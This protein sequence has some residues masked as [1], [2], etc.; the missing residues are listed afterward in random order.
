M[1]LFGSLRARVSLKVFF[2]SHQNEGYIPE[3]TQ[4]ELCIND[5]NVFIKE[6]IL[7]SNRKFLSNSPCLDEWDSKFRYK[8]SLSSKKENSHT[9]TQRDQVKKNIIV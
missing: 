4:T 5:V 9:H 7:T 8:I 3:Q 6:S 1:R 2:K